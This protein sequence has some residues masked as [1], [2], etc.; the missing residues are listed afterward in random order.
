[1]NHEAVSRYLF[2]F[3]EDEVVMLD[4]RDL[5]LYLEEDRGFDWWI[6]SKITQLNK[7]IH[8]L[9]TYSVMRWLLNW[10]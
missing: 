7:T 10:Q 6:Q 3:N 4:A 5:Y 2:D 1:V 8:R 9:D